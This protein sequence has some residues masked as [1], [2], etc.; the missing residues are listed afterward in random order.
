[1]Y[2]K[3]LFDTLMS[4][5]DVNFATFLEAKFNIQ[6]AVVSSE[7]LDNKWLAGFTSTDPLCSKKNPRNK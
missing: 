7:V 4:L 5:I 6:K 3:L 2:L 1:M